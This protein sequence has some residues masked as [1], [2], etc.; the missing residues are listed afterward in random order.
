MRAS[1]AHEDDDMPRVESSLVSAALRRWMRAV[2]ED[3]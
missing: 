1:V 3:K 2:C